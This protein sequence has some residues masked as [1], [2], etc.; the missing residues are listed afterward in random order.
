[1]NWVPFAG[2]GEVADGAVAGRA[3]AEGAGAGVELPVR[4]WAAGE[5]VLVYVL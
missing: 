1:M 2:A 5:S 4:A 3:A